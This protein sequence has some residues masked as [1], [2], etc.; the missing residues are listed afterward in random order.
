MRSADATETGTFFLRPLR[1]T[2]YAGQGASF[3][4][5]VVTGTQMSR[6]TLR[7]Q[8]VRRTRWETMTSRLPPTGLAWVLLLTCCQSPKYSQVWLKSHAVLGIALKA[9]VIGCVN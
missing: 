4:R 9:S 8:S 2:A 6:L 7:R 5:N 3:P 1:S